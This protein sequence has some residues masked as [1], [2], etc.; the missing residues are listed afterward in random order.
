M[1]IVCTGG[2]G[3]IGA[4]LIPALIDQGHSVVLLT[5]RQG[6]ESQGSFE[7]PR[8]VVWNGRGA[9]PW[10]KEVEGAGAVINFA[11]EPLDR[12][13][14]TRAQKELIVE[15]RVNATRAIV[16]AI[17]A[18]SARPE[19]LISASG[20]DYYGDT[21][22]AL[23]TESA[24]PGTGLLAETCVR[25]E[26][27]AMVAEKYGVRTVVLRVGPVLGEKGGVLQRMVLASK[28]YAGGPLGTGKQWFPWIHRD[29]LVSVIQTALKNSSY[30]GPLN[31]V[32]PE[33]ATNRQFCGALGDVLRRPCWLPVPAPLLRLAFGEMASLIL[34]GRHVVPARLADLGFSFRFPQLSAALK[35]ILRR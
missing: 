18:S 32:A 20:A 17:G 7:N 29:D 1:K 12:R 25:W 33:G 3:F 19:V 34:T 10:V 14:W 8:R 21:G 9:G 16:Q 24:P 11:G 15:S 23:V 4:A 6:R 13:R 27:E 26:R 2:T 35:D 5:R 22:D 31:A 28:W 30:S